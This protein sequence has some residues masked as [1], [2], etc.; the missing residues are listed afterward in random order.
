MTSQGSASGRFIRAVQR[1]HIRAAEI[2]LREME[3][4][5]LSNALA[6]VILFGL[7][8]DPRFERA[9]QRWLTR[10]RREAALNHRQ[11]ELL[12]AALGAL[13]SSFDKLAVN[14][15]VE[16]CRELR[17]PWPTVP[18]DGVRSV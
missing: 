18:T 14:L 7:E 10:A 11:T 9:A 15:L 8:D 16:A 6:L 5:S 17:W 1:R 4:V 2:A 12:R 3:D 13:Q